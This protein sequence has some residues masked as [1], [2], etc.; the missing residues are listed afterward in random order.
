MNEIQKIRAENQIADA[1]NPGNRPFVDLIYDLLLNFDVLIWQ[2][3]NVG[4][5]SKWTGPFKILGIE[6]ET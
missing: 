6:D 2:K 1:I 5:T 4:R 3:S